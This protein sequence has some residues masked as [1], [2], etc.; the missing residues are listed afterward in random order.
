MKRNPSIKE[1]HKMLKNGQAKLRSLKSITKRG[2]I[3]GYNKN[4][5][6]D[7]FKFTN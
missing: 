2:K 5:I 4:Y 6:R 3:K 1:M 7:W